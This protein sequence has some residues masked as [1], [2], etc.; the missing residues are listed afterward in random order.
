MLRNATDIIGRRLAATDGELGS[1][2][3]LY[4]DDAAWV[5]RYLVIDTGGWLPG[6]KVLIDPAAA[7]APAREG[8]L[9][10]VGLTREQVKQSPDIG[11]DLP[12]S[13]Q[14]EV[15]YRGHYAWPSYWMGGGL[16]NTS[17]GNYVPGTMMAEREI[18][19]R[20][21]SEGRP[22]QQQGDPNLRSAKEVKGYT[23]DATD[24]EVGHVDDFLFD[25]ETWELL[26]LIVDTRKWLPGKKVLVAPEWVDSIDWNEHQVHVDVDRASIKEAPEYTGSFDREFETRLYEHYGRE[27]YWSERGRRGSRVRI[28][29][30]TP[31]DHAA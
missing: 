8:N 16:F 26:Y 15:E 20:A 14:R 1:I 24:G 22:D 23:I 10:A 6:R 2:N 19:R 30:P 5:I 25:D 7:G 31:S 12:V 4:F 9:Y 28:D 18:S 29:G 3:D 13:K 17:A 21:R 27:P 11:T